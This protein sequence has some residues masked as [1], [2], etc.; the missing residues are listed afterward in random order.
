MGAKEGSDNVLKTLQGT[1]WSSIPALSVLVFFAV[2]VKVFRAAR[3]E[4]TTTVAI[5]SSADTVALLKGVVLTLLPGFLAGVVAA[6]IW[7]WS[8]FVVSV[9]ANTGKDAAPA[10]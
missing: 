6:G 9:D 1:V 2:T 4:T 10:K 8:G 3:M 5:V 7:W